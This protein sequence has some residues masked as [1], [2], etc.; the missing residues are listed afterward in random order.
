MTCSP[1]SGELGLNSI[2]LLSVMGLTSAIAIDNAMLPIIMSKV[3]SPSISANEGDDQVLW[4][5]SKSS[6]HS[7]FTPA[8]DPDDPSKAQRDLP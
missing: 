8:G 2:P 3:A 5:S 7:E 6:D 1:G 4:S